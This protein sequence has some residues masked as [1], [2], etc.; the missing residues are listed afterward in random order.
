MA[1]APQIVNPAALLDVTTERRETHGLLPDPEPREV[2]CT[3]I[4]V[5][6][7]LVEPPH[8]FEGR[9]P[10]ALEQHAPR[11]ISNDEGIECWEYDGQ[12]YRQIGLN[13]VAGRP[14]EDW[15]L[16]AAN[17]SEMRP[18]CFDIH[19]RIRDMDINGVWASVNF[20]SQITGFC[21]TVFARSS[22]QD[23]GFAVMQAWNDWLCEEWWS[24]YP[25]RIV[26]MGITWLTDPVRGAEEIRRNAERGFTAVTLPEQPHRIGLPS[27]F[28]GYWDP[29]LRACEE[30]DTVV[31][32]HVGSTGL[33]AMPTDAP[34]LE[35][36]ATLFGALS[37]NTCA[38]WLW[39]GVALRF[40]GLKIALA[41]GGIGWVPMLKDR[42]DYMMAH[43]GHEDGLWPSSELSPTD[44]LER[45]FWFCSIDDPSLV[46][47]IDR[48]GPD[49]IM[50]EVDYPHA[51]S[52]WPDT[53]AFV[54]EHWAS[55]GVETLRKVSH[56]NAASL[57]RHPLPAVTLP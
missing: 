8:L 35:L 27:L 57:F 1:D 6:D 20:P 28:S 32:L 14:K 39:S 13:A 34:Q 15:L 23:V 26:P 29:I 3:I 49:R 33:T 36:G 43:G 53:Q 41:E 44:V 48:I 42:L 7:H 45:N 25:E 47:V 4:S 18:G 37:L 38:E 55:V 50:L 40:P 22:D 51:D 56:L 5:D 54:Q 19:E 2:L 21:G 30:T 17:F 24:P 46:P 9:L 10:K 16:Q 52:T 31:C 11:V 12:L